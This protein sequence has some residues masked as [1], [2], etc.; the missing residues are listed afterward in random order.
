MICVD[1]GSGR[2]NLRTAA[3]LADDGHVL[4]CQ[5]QASDS[6]WFLPGG[7]VDLMEATPDTLRREM[8]EELGAQVEVGPLQLV[9]ENFFTLDG[10]SYHEVGFYYRVTFTDPA[11][12][13]KSRSWYGI[14][15]GPYKLNVRWFR[16][17]EL[18]QVNLLPAFLPE[19]LSNLT[20]GTRHIVNRG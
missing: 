6:F 15:D 9:V 16:L 7:R 2:F 18:D 17:D 11:F 4:L 5:S 10:R 14:V 1:I 3:I 20:E 8:A 19:A 12:L 13:D